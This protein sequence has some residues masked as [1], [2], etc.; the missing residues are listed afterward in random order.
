M[1]FTV[2]EMNLLCIFDTANREKLLAEIGESM[3]DVYDPEMRDIME[4]AAAKLTDITD[5]EFSA[6]TFSA[7]T[8]DAYDFE[9]WEE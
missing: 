9:E 4:S 6:L 1:E 2:E 3:T 7:E 5:E 8:S